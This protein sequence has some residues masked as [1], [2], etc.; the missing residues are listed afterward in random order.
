MLNDLILLQAVAQTLRPRRPP[1][2]IRLCSWCR[3]PRRNPREPPDLRPQVLDDGREHR[4]GDDGAE[5]L[6]DQEAE[7]QPRPSPSELGVQ[8]DRAEG[9]PDCRDLRDD[10]ERDEFEDFEV[11]GET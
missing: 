7:A 10:Y 5:H 3:R 2:N 11:C 1:F 4:D 8:R 9:E 6:V